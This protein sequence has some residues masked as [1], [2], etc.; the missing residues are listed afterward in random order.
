MKATTGWSYSPGAVDIC[1]ECGGDRI[2]VTR[3]WLAIDGQRLRDRQCRDCGY[4]FT[5]IEGIAIREGGGTDGSNE[6]T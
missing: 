4:S 1:P 6:G 3:S 5:T 2:H